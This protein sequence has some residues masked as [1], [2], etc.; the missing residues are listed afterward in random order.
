MPYIGLRSST[1]RH[2]RQLALA[3]GGLDEWRPTSY[4][5]QLALAEA[6]AARFAGESAVAQFRAA[7]G[8]AE[9]LCAYMALEP[10]LDLAMEPLEHGG[11]DEGR[12]VL[13]ECWSAVRG[14][15]AQALERRAVRLATRTRVPLPESAR[16]QG[17]LSRLT[18]REREVLDLLATGATNKAIAATP[19]ASARRP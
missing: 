19:C 14:M 8:L 9:R 16:G 1:P 5:F 13:V 7:V 2:A 11:R 17:R 6:H 10:R 18:P 15:G 3:R 4:G 12:Q